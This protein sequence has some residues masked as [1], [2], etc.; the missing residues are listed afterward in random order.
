MY[1]EYLDLLR[2][3]GE[4]LPEMLQNPR[5]RSK[6]AELCSTDFVVRV[7]RQIVSNHYAL[8]WEEDLTTDVRRYLIGIQDQFEKFL[9]AF[10]GKRMTLL[11]Y[12]VVCR[13]VVPILSPAANESIP[14]LSDRLPD[15]I[16]G[17]FTAIP[18]QSDLPHCGRFPH[19]VLLIEKENPR[20]Y[21]VLPLD[22]SCLE[23]EEMIFETA[24]LFSLLSGLEV[25]LVLSNEKCVY[26]QPDCGFKMSRNR[27]TGGALA[28]RSV[29]GPHLYPLHLEP[30]QAAYD[31]YPE[32]FTWSDEFD[33]ERNLYVGD[34]YVAVKQLITPNPELEGQAL[35]L[36]RGVVA[37][38]LPL[39]AKEWDN[40]PVLLKKQAG[41]LLTSLGIAGVVKIIDR[42]GLS[43]VLSRVT[44]PSEFLTSPFFQSMNCAMDVMEHDLKR[45]G[46][47]QKLNSIMVPAIGAGIFSLARF[48]VQIRRLAGPFDNE[49]FWQHTQ[50]TLYPAAIGSPLTLLRL[51]VWRR[52]QHL[53]REQVPP[54]DA[55]GGSFERAQEVLG[56]LPHLFNINAHGP[57]W[58]W[59][60][61]ST[62][63]V[64]PG[65][66]MRVDGE[67]MPHY[68]DGP[69]CID[70]DGTTKYFIHGEEKWGEF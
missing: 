28:H 6:T 57:R 49:G 27:P 7:F 45:A 36:A 19:L 24:K 70:P 46:L 17:E 68:E 43:T 10:L 67:G 26:I 2:R 35:E 18:W 21:T 22:P 16:D 59:Q 37:D 33:G 62:L 25:C 5:D 39:I 40:E 29:T 42:K 58:M 50:S 47:Y 8:R 64:L 44:S 69:A 55:P 11:D 65:V 38:F 32:L 63:W 54:G 4:F 48:F 14:H 51:E 3:T 12:G 30:L 31:E 15:A 34:G 60:E 13:S 9:D 56:A 61:G 23:H 41:D 53:Y 66:V 1:P 20:V 52:V